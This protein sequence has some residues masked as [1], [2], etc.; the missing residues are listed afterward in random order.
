MSSAVTTDSARPERG[1]T[2]GSDAGA[3]ET[4]SDG[5]ESTRHR[6]AQTA[7]EHGVRHSLRRRE[8]RE[9]RYHPTPWTAVMDAHR[10]IR[11]PNA[12]SARLRGARAAREVVRGDVSDGE[13]PQRGARRPRRI[14]QDHA[15]R[16]PA[17]H[18]RGDP[19]HRAGRGRH[20]RLRLRPRGGE[21]QHLGLA[22]GRAVRVRRAQGQR[23]STRP[24]TPTSSTDVAAAMRVGRPRGVRRLRGRGRRGADRGR[25]ADGRRDRPPAHRLRQQAR[26]RAG[27]V[28]ADAR[29]AEGPVR[30]RHRA[31][32]AAR[33]ARRPSSAA[34]IDLL[35]DTA[36]TYADGSPR[37]NEGP[38]PDDMAAEEHSVH[39]ALVEGI[40]VADDDLM[41]RYL[42]DETIDAV[43]ARPRAR[44]GH[45]RR[46]RVPGAVRERDEAHRRRPARA[47]HRRGGPGAARRPAT[48]ARPR[49]SCSRRSSTR[50]SGT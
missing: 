28:R 25:V 33:S 39:D 14:R 45:R 49:C 19:P 22:R 12:G 15:G 47:L 10:S 30:C 16:G 24:A 11:S 48:T 34:S 23:R 9:A 3:L 8:R 43:R 4:A 26:P 18:R 38:V 29:P 35:S 5:R 2:V 20:H 36:E 7:V 41:E 27:V 40:V 44:E 31:A 46:D 42:A 6:G 13:D 32:R 37:G 21:A 50:T 17:V 1:Q